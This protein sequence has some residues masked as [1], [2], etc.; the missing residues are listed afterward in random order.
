[1]RGNQAAA[2]L[3]WNTVPTVS[4]TSPARAARLLL[5][6]L[7]LLLALPLAAS[8]QPKVSVDAPLLPL[9]RAGAFT[10]IHVNIV[11][12]EPLDGLIKV[13][14]GDETAPIVRPYTVGRQS[15]RRVSVP[16]VLPPWVRE[17]NVVVTHGRK[18]IGRERL[19]GASTSAGGDALHVVVVGEDPLGFT[20][21]R[22]ITGRPVLGH[23]DC[24]DVREVRVETVLPAA[25]PNVWFGWTSADLVIWRRPDPADLTPEQQAALR[26]WV[27]SGGTLVVGLAD[28]WPSW[29]GSP[30]GGLSGVSVEGS[31]VSS[32]ALAALLALGGAGGPG[33]GALPVLA[34]RPGSATLRGDG[35]LPIADHHVGAG[36]VVTLGFDPAAGEVRGALDRAQFWRSLLGLHDESGQ[37]TALAGPPLRRTP[38]PCSDDADRASWGFKT[39]AQVAAEWR[40]TLESALSSFSRANPLPLGTVLLFGVFYL[41]LIGPMDYLIARKLRRPML[42]WITFPVVAIG[43]S[44]LAAAVISF[45]KSGDTELRCVEVVD[46]FGA[47][48]VRG[49]GWCAMWSSRRQDVAI[50]VPRGEGVVLPGGGADLT[51]LALNGRSRDPII[52][53]TR[54][55]LSYRASQWAVSTWRSAWMSETEGSIAAVPTADGVLVSNASGLALADAWIVHGG[56]MWHVGPVP[57]GGTAPI[58]GP[59]ESFDWT[60]ITAADRVDEPGDGAPAD[61]LHVEAVFDSRPRSWVD[62]W[63]MLSDPYTEHVA[64]LP[65]LFATDVPVLV[66]TVSGGIAPP[67]PRDGGAGLKTF[68]IL[69][70]PLP[71]SLLEDLP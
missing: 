61:V 28:N 33:D 3:S 63:A 19:V 8:G 11:T 57:D 59:A 60:R 16:V 23:P 20:T 9:A 66:S 55:G 68:A 22:T 49:S 21:L 12:T 24:G 69:R 47:D 30:L 53:P 45:Q 13:D 34:L 4:N 51:D 14:F 42:T 25:L 52:E 48:G 7:S 56:S 64:R 35:V 15:A 31:S 54:V 1:M 26:G 70:A 58:A 43:F 40:N 62:G 32:D 41:V 5:A 65:A 38:D 10:P 17:I 6:A 2:P 44:V 29:T 37:G 46:W 27:G 67:L 50:P 71:L 18:E 39:A 36:R